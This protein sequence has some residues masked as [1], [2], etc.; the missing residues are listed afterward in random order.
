[1]NCYVWLTG[2]VATLIAMTTAASRADE[3]RVGLIVENVR[4]HETLYADLDVSMHTSFVLGPE[5]KV[6]FDP[7]MLE[8][9][10]KDYSTSYVRQGD[11]YRLEVDGD[12]YTKEGE[13]YTCD[14][15]IAFDGSTTRQ[16]EQN[17]IGNIVAGRRTD[18]NFIE[19][20]MLLLRS[21][22]QFPLSTFLGGHDAI[23]SNPDN[24]WNEEETLT[25]TYL[26]EDEIEGLK[27][28]CVAL[29][30]HRTGTEG[31]VY[32]WELWLP[33]A[34]NY[35]PAQVRSYIRRF[36]E[37]SPIGQ[38]IVHQWKEV[39]PG[40][41]WPAEAEYIGW[42][43]FVMRREKRNQLRWKEEYKLDSVSLDPNHE[44]SFFQD[45]PF[46]SGTAVYEVVNDNI[47]KSY[48]VGAPSSPVGPEPTDWVFWLVFANVVVIAAIAVVIVIRAK[49]RISSDSADA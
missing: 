33:E 8:F 19:P 38:A 4:Q 1:M 30:G 23:L 31:W 25:V 12:S 3:N 24:R 43:K 6:G 45:V 15:I 13:S 46:P 42:D 16:L 34:R 47:T 14:R 21:Q 26:G 7:A 40:V 27:C 36:S 5:V 44:L 18:P 20:H 35:I 49:R 39:I 32:R 28:H 37:D 11:W 41:W 2:L 29:T 48:E 10:K 17:K 22:F 9:V